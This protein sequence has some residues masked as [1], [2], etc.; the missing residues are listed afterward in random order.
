LRSIPRRFWGNPFV[1]LIDFG[2]ALDRKVASVS[3]SLSLLGYGSAAVSAP[4][5]HADAGC[6]CRF[7]GTASVYLD[8]G[9]WPAMHRADGLAWQNSSRIMF[10]YM[11][12]SK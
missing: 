8:C 6:A 9:H 4:G 11:P 2:A 7:R 12:W 3:S 10:V 1:L 5:L